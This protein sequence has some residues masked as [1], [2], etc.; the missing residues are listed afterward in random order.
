[1][2]AVKNT[3][4]AACCHYGGDKSPPRAP[5]HSPKAGHRQ[6]AEGVHPPAPPARPYAGAPRSAATRQVKAPTP[7]A[8]ATAQGA[9]ATPDRPSPR[10][11]RDAV[12]GA[13]AGRDFPPRLDTTAQP[14]Q[15]PAQPRPHPAQPPRTGS[16]VDSRRTQQKR[17]RAK[18]VSHALAEG[19]AQLGQVQGSP[20]RFAYLA[21]LGCSSR[22]RQEAGVVRGEYC[23]ARWCVVCNR[24]R[25]AKLWTAY[26]PTLDAWDDA[27]F[28]TLTL[29][30]VPAKA[31]HS[32]VREMIQAVG[33]IKRGMRR[34]DGIAFRAV[35]K[36]EVTYNRERADFHPH[37]H[38]AIDSTAAAHALVRRWL[39]MFPEASP[40]AQDIRPAHNPAELFKY[41]TKLVTKGLDGTRSTPPLWALDVIFKALKGLR[42]IQPMGFRVTP[43]AETLGADDGAVT[44]DAS[45]PAPH[46]TTEPT[47]WE[48]LAGRVQDWV[49]LDTGEVLSGHEPTPTHLRLLASITDAGTAE[50][51][52][53]P[54]YFPTPREVFDAAISEG[55][56]EAPQ[57]G[58][59]AWNPQPR[60]PLNA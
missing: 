16:G 23:N 15:N 49:N 51:C 34:T 39:R 9:D 22:L 53:P 25:T 6:P 48:W 36:L 42:T 37:L 4:V 38:V 17:A 47:D 31:L 29:P 13:V 57:L 35:R 8:W 11:G 28:V 41:V 10:R 33:L 7:S 44:L 50:L 19:L 18:G 40:H 20:L 54:D 59:Q 14:S 32:A 30:N 1:M 52:V 21:S 2:P 27:Q 26:G 5:E 58:P 45:T 3:N 43:E 46:A 24:I 56:P 55:T 12:A 60:D